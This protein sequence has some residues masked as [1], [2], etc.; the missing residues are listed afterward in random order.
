MNEYIYNLTEF[1]NNLCNSSQ[2]ITEIEN[3]AITIALDRIDTTSTTINIWFKA[4][5]S[6]GEETLL[7]SLVSSHIAL[8]DIPDTVEVKIVENTTSPK[9][10][11]DNLKITMQPRVGSGATIISHNFGDPCTWYEKSVL[12]TDEVLTTKVNAV[13]DIYKCINLNIIDIEHGRLTFDNRVDQKYKIQVK[14]NDVTVTTGFTFNYELGEVTFQTPLTIS[15]EV[16]LTYYYATTNEFTITPTSGKKL[17]V[18]HVELQFS[19]DIDM[20]NKTHCYFEERGYNP[21]DLPNK[22]TYKTA[23]YKN[24]MNFIDESNNK[25]F[26]TIPARDNMINAMDIFV[27]E[28]PVSRIMKSTQGAEVLIYMLDVDP[29]SPT[30]GLKTKALKNKDGNNLERAVA[31]FY[32]LSETDV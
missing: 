30:Y 1:T 2:L 14:V 29:N 20:H 7:D 4:E 5:I 25:M 26:N 6:V 18:E 8:A 23:I 21:Y 22:I 15:D 10:A 24:L 32:C 12:V 17:K 16:K 28:Y 13:Y 27:W 3:S 9:D 11:D 31:T 19:V